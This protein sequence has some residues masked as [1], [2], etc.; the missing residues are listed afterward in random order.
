M[1]IVGGYQDIWNSDIGA[2]ERI[3]EWGATGDSEG[4][5]YSSVAWNLNSS[6]WE[7]SVAVLH[8]V[9]AL[10][11]VAGNPPE[12]LPNP[13]GQKIIGCKQRTQDADGMRD[14]ILDTAWGYIDPTNDGQLIAI[15]RR[16]A[17]GYNDWGRSELRV[18]LE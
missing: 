17:P 16:W 7:D 5:V 14:F 6:K 11:L 1:K 8:L 12:L 4:I 2:N 10:R 3:N 9:P 15:G 13:Q 18:Y